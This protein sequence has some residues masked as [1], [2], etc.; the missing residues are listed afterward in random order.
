MDTSHIWP[1]AEIATTAHQRNPVFLA[2]HHFPCSDLSPL[3]PFHPSC[4]HQCSNPTAHQDSQLQQTH[5]AQG[6]GQAQWCQPPWIRWCHLVPARISIIS[7]FLAS[8]S[9][10][11]M[12][13]TVVS[14]TQVIIAALRGLL[15]VATPMFT[16]TVSR[17]T[18]ETPSFVFSV[19]TRRWQ[20]FPSFVPTRLES[21]LQP[22]R[23]RLFLNNVS[24]IITKKCTHRIVVSKNLDRS[25]HANF[26]TE[27]KAIGKITTDDISLAGFRG[28]PPSPAGAHFPSANE[29]SSHGTILV[30][31][32]S[33]E[34]PLRLGVHKPVFITWALLLSLTTHSIAT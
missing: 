5:C 7:W 1:G 22:S 20:T 12:V 28:L 13:S 9:L 32:T 27:I 4:P 23:Y 34:D 30:A 2:H 31:V 15:L 21:C 8:W 24:D 14:V 6:I 16:L 26:T 33:T 17:I 18:V 25:Q 10:K 19:L 3:L 11:A 29:V